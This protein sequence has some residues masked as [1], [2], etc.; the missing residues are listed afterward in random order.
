M[1]KVALLSVY[2]KT[3][4][5]EFAKE[6]TGLGWEIVSSGGTAKT[7]S[8]AGVKVKDVAEL[9][10][11]GAI[12]GHR[13]VTLSREIHA[14]LLSREI[15]EDVKE[16][17]ALGI[18][19][20]DLV[21]VDLYPLKE[22]I[23]K[24][25]S[26]TESVIEKTDIG[27][28]TMLRS[29]AKGRRIVIADPADRM[30]VIEW[31]KAGEPEKEAFITALAAKAEYI[32]AD[33]CLASAMYHGKGDYAG[34]MGQKKIVC[35]YGENG[36]QV[37]ASYNSSG[38][39]DPLGLDK[40]KLIAGT[41]PSYNNMCDIDRLLQTVSHISAS[42]DINRGKVPCIAVGVKHG[43]SCGAAIGTNTNEVAQKMIMGDP[44]AIFGGLVLLNF[45]VTE[46][47]AETLVTHGMPE[48]VRRPL[49]GIIAPSFDEGAVVMFK[50]KGD[51]C[52][53]LV[54]PEI[55]KMGKGSLDK[56]LRYRYVRGGLLVQPNYTF[57]LDLNDPELKK[58]GKATIQQED[59][60]LMA[61]AICDTSNSNTVTMVRHGQLIANGVGQQARVRGSKLATNL[62]SYS[63]HESEGASASSDSFFPFTDGVEVLQKAG[64]KAILGTS[65]SIK[66]K[67]VIKFCED[68][69]VVL[70][71][72]PDSKGRGFFGH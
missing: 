70:Y 42:F 5:V 24:P 10:G 19:R 8:G 29:A 4:I 38:S 14:G 51:K 45:N 65:G 43:N 17:A 7:L 11:G 37:P 46:E 57:V 71:L 15:E 13:V 52:R 41:D 72:Y 2:D 59:D 26:T 27:G 53:L 68:K 44:L 33:Y 61:K 6:L 22:E 67:E 63:D 31:L 39:D 49:D 48:G 40:F 36:Y 20:I 62:V 50:R 66:D 25:G 69:G 58:Y 55:A 21:C 23:A 56:G 30:K 16:M 47:V 1:A 54:N 32:I 9:V 35:K 28:P 64:I 18:P 60:M 12:L 3:G 34:V